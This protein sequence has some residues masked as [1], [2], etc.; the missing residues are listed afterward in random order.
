[1]FCTDK[2]F[3]KSWQL[4]KRVLYSPSIFEGVDTYKTGRKLM[5]LH[6]TKNVSDTRY[7]VSL[8]L[9][10]ARRKKKIHLPK[11]DTLTT[12]SSKSKAIENTDMPSMAPLVWNRMVGS[13]D[14]TGFHQNSYTLVFLSVHFTFCFSEENITFARMTG[15]LGGGGW[16]GRSEIMG[17]Q[18]PTRSL[19]R[20]TSVMIYHRGASLSK[21]HTDL[22]ICHCT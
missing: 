11:S 18:N 8:P 5:L 13:Y 1:M 2:W 12:I 20:I 16:F 3:E 22:L 7:Q 17:K 6:G 21:Q 15:T 9:E 19:E 14:S 4:F 10:E